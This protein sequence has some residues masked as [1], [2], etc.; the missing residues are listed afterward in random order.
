[1]A[2]E[3]PT[4]DYI[5]YMLRLWREGEGVW[6]G[7]VE[8]PHTGERRAFANVESLLAFLRQQTEQAT[9]PPAEN[10]WRTD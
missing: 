3:Q 4:A 6:R 7:T 10:D 8:N 2:V 9:P 1:M 5:A